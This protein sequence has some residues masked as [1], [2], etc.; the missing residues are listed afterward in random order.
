M[1]RLKKYDPA[2][3]PLLGG[4]SGGKKEEEEEDKE[5]PCADRY[6]NLFGCFFMA[7]L[8]FAG[9]M[10]IAPFLDAYYRYQA[11]EEARQHMLI[12]EAIIKDTN[13]QVHK[14][15][16]LMIGEPNIHL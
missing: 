7:T 6:P 2:N 14:L 8:L 4:N 13:E 9:F 5:K 3:V 12:Q 10:L 16:N 15:V 11:V 1:I